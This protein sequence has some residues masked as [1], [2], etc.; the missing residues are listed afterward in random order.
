MELMH[1]VENSVKKD[2]NVTETKLKT[3]FKSAVTKTKK[4]LLSI[5]NNYLAEFCNPLLKL[6]HTYFDYNSVTKIM[7]RKTAKS[8]LQNTTIEKLLLRHK[9]LQYAVPNYDIRFIVKLIVGHR[10]LINIK[11]VTGAEAI[12]ILSKEKHSCM[13][14]KFD[15]FGDIYKLNKDVVEVWYMNDGKNMARAI[16][17]LGKYCGFV[18]SDC[19]ILKDY[20]ANILNVIGLK[21]VTLS[22]FQ[23]PVKLSNI[24]SFP[25]IDG[26]P[27][28]IGV[29]G[30]D[31]LLV[32][33]KSESALQKTLKSLGVTVG[34]CSG[35]SG[36]LKSYR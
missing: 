17:W 12:E 31:G 36:K 4:Y 16:V 19:V 26:K 23:V 30:E 5:G 1:T 9:T 20:F 35:L 2:T 8:A 25:Y 3:D 13:R 11:K 7:F 32:F 29:N 15:K 28:V 14:G 21:P 18:Y 10:K 22:N 34:Y 33:N 24:K 27:F 6:T